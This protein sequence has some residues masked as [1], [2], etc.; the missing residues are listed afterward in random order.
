MFS[1]MKPDLYG[2]VTDAY[3]VYPWEIDRGL[4]GRDVAEGQPEI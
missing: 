3:V 2:D 4:L 1:N